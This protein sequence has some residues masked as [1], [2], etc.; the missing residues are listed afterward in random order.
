M[1]DARK[2]VRLCMHDFGSDQGTS[3][4]NGSGDSLSGGGGN[5]LAQQ[6]VFLRGSEHF[7]CLVQVA[8][9]QR[10]IVSSAKRVGF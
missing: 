7:L 8:E 2:G 1:S 6:Y 10:L 5:V 9:Q 3:P 4:L